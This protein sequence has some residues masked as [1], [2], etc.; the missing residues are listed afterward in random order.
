[1]KPNPQPIW[2]KAVEEMA[3]SSHYG[4]LGE[5]ERLIVREAIRRAH[6]AG[7]LHAHSAGGDPINVADIRAGDNVLIEDT[8]GNMYDVT[9]DRVSGHTVTWWD[10][11]LT[12]GQIESTYLISRPIMHPDPDKHP[13][14]LVT[15]YKDH[16]DD[17]VLL[18]KPV[19]YFWDGDWYAAPDMPPLNPFWVT[20][21]VPAEMVAK[22]A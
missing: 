11:S 13:F 22:N 2:D 20:D 12:G 8:A 18:D 15:G 7:I 14:I 1:M 3:G 21:W 17:G 4:L 10:M 5:T 19:P 9:V 16:T 6:H